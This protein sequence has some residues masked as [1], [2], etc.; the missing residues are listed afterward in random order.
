MKTT[1][2]IRN[3]ASATVVSVASVAPILAADGA[4][5]STPRAPGGAIVGL[6]MWYICSRRKAKEIGAVAGVVIRPAVWLPYFYRSRR[7]RRVFQTHDWIPVVA[8][9]V[10][11]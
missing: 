9:S 10:S 4:E 5:P 1:S 3:I 6:I 2:T 7:V 8:A 11:A